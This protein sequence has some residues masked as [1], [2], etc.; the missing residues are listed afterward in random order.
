M[1]L[2]RLDDRSRTTIIRSAD[3]D[4]QWDG[5]DTSTDVCI[6]D[7]FTVVKRNQYYDLTVAGNPEAGEIFYLL[8]VIYST[9][10]SFSHHSGHVEYVGLY[11]DEN[12]AWENLRRINDNANPLMLLDETEDGIEEYQ[13]H[14]PWIGYFESIENVDVCQVMRED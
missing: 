6:G 11:R 13:I 1:A 5:D 2:I 3:P 10:D 8:I 12:T 9:G 14:P 4:K 7:T